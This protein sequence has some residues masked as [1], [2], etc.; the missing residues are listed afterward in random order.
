MHGA[1]SQFWSKSK[2]KIQ[3]STFDQLMSGPSQRSI[4]QIEAHTPRR[5]KP[6]LWSCAGRGIQDGADGGRPSRNKCS[7]V[8]HGHCPCRCQPGWLQ[9]QGKGHGHPPAASALPAPPRD[10]PHI[11]AAESQAPAACLLPLHRHRPP[12][13]GR[14]RLCLG[15]TAGRQPQGEL[16][17]RLIH[18]VESLSMSQSEHVA[19]LLDRGSGSFS[20]GCSISPGHAPINSRNSPACWHMSMPWQ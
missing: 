9:G 6:G 16:L 19:L 2:A 17:N 4:A 1:S 3:I 5:L 13:S 15:H 18:S 8:D 7:G 11:S 20:P 14:S 12:S 10:L